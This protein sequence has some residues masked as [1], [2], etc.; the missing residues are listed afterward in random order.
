M[1]LVGAF[2]IIDSL[3]DLFRDYRGMN[4]RDVVNSLRELR[5]EIVDEFSKRDDLLH[6]SVPIAPELDKKE[7]PRTEA[8]AESKPVTA[9]ELKLAL[10]K[11]SRNFAEFI[12]KIQ[13]VYGVT[14][15]RMG[16]IT[17]YT[18]ATVCN[19]K[20]GKT[21]PRDDG[22]QRICRVLQTEFGIPIEVSRKFIRI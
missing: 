3:E 19:W 8:P 6:A 5:F 7:E 22:K 10:I 9:D 16:E 11:E 14:N 12:S 17:G 18:D 15:K 13:K 20:S 21:M 2:R 1:S 4:T